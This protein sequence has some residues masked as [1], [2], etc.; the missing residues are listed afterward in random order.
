MKDLAQ[1][2]DALVSLLNRM[3]VDYVLMG[4]LVVRAYSIP[5]STED[6]DVTLALEHD[7]LPELYDALEEQDYVV[8]E[9]YKTGWLD[10]LKG[11][12]LVKLRRYVGGHGIDV[13]VFL[14]ESR[15]QEEIMRRRQMAEVEGRQLWIAS[16]EDLVLLKLVSGRPRDWIDVADV[17]FTQGDLDVQYMRRWAV[18]LEIEKELERALSER[19]NERQ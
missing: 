9:P 10:E 12:H 2:L 1:T 8:P 6:V 3:K 4:G 14:V 16:P 7:R 5:R 19:T 15:F 13:D 11:M 17:F 18:E